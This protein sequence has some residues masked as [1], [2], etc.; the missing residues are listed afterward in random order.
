[1][2]IYILNC[3]IHNVSLHYEIQNVSLH[4]EL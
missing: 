1:M 4:S 2:Y 3:T